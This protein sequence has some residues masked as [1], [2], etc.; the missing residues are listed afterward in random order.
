LTPVRPF[1][2]FSGAPASAAA[3]EKAGALRRPLQLL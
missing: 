2:F 1:L 3:P